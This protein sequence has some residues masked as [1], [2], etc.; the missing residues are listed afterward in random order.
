MT[1]PN[2][3]LALG[4]ERFVSLTT[5]RRSG[6]PVATTVWIAREGESLVVITAPGSGKVKRLRRDPRVELRPGSR[7]GAVAPDAPVASGTAT[8]L[9]E[10]AAHA[11]PRRALAAKYGLEWRLLSLLEWF[12]GERVILRITP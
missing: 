4:D 9:D 10:P 12:G 8:I 11:G 2:D 6:E 7:R 5:F 3:L 1:A